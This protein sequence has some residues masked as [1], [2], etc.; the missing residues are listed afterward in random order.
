[1][2]INFIIMATTI[3]ILLGG[4]LYIT[5]YITQDDEAQQG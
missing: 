2:T 4:F 1:M 3:L 5:L